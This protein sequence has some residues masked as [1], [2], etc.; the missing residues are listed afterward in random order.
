MDRFEWFLEKSTELGISEITPVI[1]NRSERKIVNH[2]RMQ[3][4]IVSAMKQSMQPYLPE[5]HKS[6]SFRGFLQ[7]S[8]PGQKFIPHC[9]KNSLPLLKD[10]LSLKNNVIICIG[11]E[12]DFTHEEIELAI[13]NGYEE[14]TLGP[15]RLRTETAGLVACH[16]VILMNS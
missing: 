4:I 7:Q 16:T 10:T 3:K 11:P 8:L 15:A 5:L 13:Q 6:A 14:V 12:G 1:C 2:E 9:Q